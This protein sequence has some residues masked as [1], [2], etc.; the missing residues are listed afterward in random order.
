MFFVY[1]LANVETQNIAGF[2]NQGDLVKQLC[3]WSISLHQ[4]R[5]S[6]VIS[7][8]HFKFCQKNAIPSFTNVADY[9]NAR[10]QDHSPT[11][12]YHTFIRE[13][14]YRNGP[15]SPLNLC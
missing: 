10:K 13:I 1:C 6:I 11:I 8:Q 15:F 12:N 9:T 14:Q 2:E 4:S 3:F 5:S 7:S